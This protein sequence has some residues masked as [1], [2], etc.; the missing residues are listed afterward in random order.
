MPDLIFLHAPP[1]TISLGFSAEPPSSSIFFR[2]Y[3]IVPFP[4][5][6]PFVLPF[7]SFFSAAP[8]CRDSAREGKFP[9]VPT[10]FRSPGV[11]SQASHP[12]ACGRGQ[13]PQGA[14]HGPFAI[15]YSGQ[16]LVPV[17]F[18]FCILVFWLPPQR[19][20]PFFFPYSP[21]TSDSPPLLP[22]RYLWTPRSF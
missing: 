9:S 14:S 4:F 21:P 3:P 15:Q 12:L 16:L 20:V 22:N 8:D 13:L 2:I 19:R 17:F 11:L 5:F 7:C 18:F 10:P 1:P 6:F